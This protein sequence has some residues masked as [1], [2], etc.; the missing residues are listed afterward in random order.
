MKFS[1]AINRM[2]ID[3]SAVWGVHDK[4][5]ALKAEGEDIILFSIGDPDLP[6]LDIR[7]YE[8][9]YCVMVCLSHFS[10]GL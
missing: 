6:T 1:R 3:T 8:E 2:A 5:T 10:Y 4:A 7:L 9:I